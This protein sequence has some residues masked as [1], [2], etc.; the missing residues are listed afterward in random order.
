MTDESVNE[1]HRMKMYVSLDIGGTAIKYG[2]ISDSA[3]I[4]FKGSTKTEAEKGGP[5]ILKKVIGIVED[6]LTRTQDT[7]SGICI[8]TAGMVDTKEGSIFYASPLIPNYAGIQYKKILEER[9]HIPCEVENDVNCAGLAGI[10]LRCGKGKP[11]CP[12]PYGWGTGIG[13]CIVID[14]KVF[15]G[16]GN[17]ACEVGYMHMGDSDFQTLGAASI[18]VKRVAAAKEEPEAQWNGYRIFQLAGEG[19]P[20][21]KEA[22]DQMCDCLGK[23]ISNICYVLNPQIVVLG[24]GIM[25]QEEYLRPRLE[26]ALARYLVSSIYEKTELAFARHQNDAGML[27]AYYHFLER[28]GKA[29]S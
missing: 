21:C 29:R 25:A 12:D 4:I 20:I 15:R 1:D 16:F 11:H 10:Q 13:G 5:E 8:S 6:L 2:L 22:I 26:K 27:G 17:S 7:V 19:D 9:F 18:L 24:G 28:Q 23:G 14:G 3:E